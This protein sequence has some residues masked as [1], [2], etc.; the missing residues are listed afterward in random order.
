MLE[1]IFKLILRYLQ[2][3]NIKKK[4]Q[5][6]TKHIICKVQQKKIFV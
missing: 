2:T 5:T 6:K 4:K 3:C 1:V